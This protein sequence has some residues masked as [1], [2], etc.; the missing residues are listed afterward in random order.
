MSRFD[1]DHVISD[2]L[3]RIRVLETTQPMGYSSVS[4]GRSRFR[5]NESILV[6]GSGK[7]DGWWIITGTQRVAGRLEGSGTFDWTGPWALRGNGSIPGDVDLVGALKAKGAWEFVG[8]GKI[9][10]NTD[11]AGTLDVLSR[12]TLGPSGYIQV[13][14]I[15][16]DRA[17]SRGG[18][19]SATNYLDLDAPITTAKDTILES[20]YVTKDASVVGK[21]TVS[22]TKNFRIPHPTDDGKYLLHAATESPVSGVEYW[23]E[24]ALSSDGECIVDLPH[25]FEALTKPE[26]RAVLVTPRGFVADWGDIEDGSFTVTGTPGGRFSWLVKAVRKDEHGGRFEVEEPVYGPLRED[27]S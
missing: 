27:F 13:G 12:L 14:P 25:Y 5:G 17:G 22:G 8:N 23:G 11:I 9:T 26:G 10:G 4:E 19:V 2:L 15:R 24:E 18:R 16:I 20:V 6:E 3:R 21:L 7:V 1:M